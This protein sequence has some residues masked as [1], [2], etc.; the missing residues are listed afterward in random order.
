MSLLVVPAP[1]A[2]GS[3]LWEGNTSPRQSQWAPWVFPLATGI[4]R[5]HGQPPL[6]DHPWVH[7]W[8]PTQL[9]AQPK[10]QGG[11]CWWCWGCPMAGGWGADPSL[12]LAILKPE[13]CS[14]TGALAQSPNSHPSWY[15][16]THGLKNIQ[17]H[18]PVTLPCPKGSKILCLVDY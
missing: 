18:D 17:H 15:R 5:R 1:V 10:P 16:T 14:C 4:A 11:R 9:Q 12:L 7:P 6:L 8:Q 13:G 2:G 3:L